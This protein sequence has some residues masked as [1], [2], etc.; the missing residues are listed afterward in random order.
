MLVSNSVVDNPVRQCDQLQVLPDRQ[1]A[2]Q[3]R[4]IRGE[5][6]L[7]PGAFGL[8]LP[9]RVESTDADGALA[10]LQEPAIA[11]TAVDLPVPFGPISR[12]HSPG[13]TV[14]LR[15]AARRVGYGFG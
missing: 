11:G 1:V 3:E 14:R 7:L 5:R 13:A 4:G 9:T 15:S 6:K 12:T 8:G 10:R 2:V